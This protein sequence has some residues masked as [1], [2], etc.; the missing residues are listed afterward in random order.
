MVE[1][2]IRM[3][4]NTPE[5]FT[6]P[7][8]LGNPREFTILEL[9]EKIIA[10]TGSSSRIQFKPLPVNDPMQRKPDIALAREKLE[11]DPAIQLDAGLDRTIA[12]FE[13]LLAGKLP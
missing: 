11:W 2:F 4:D 10:K 13:N 5:G 6:G 7:V 1:G 8:N 9:A 12:Y 3:M